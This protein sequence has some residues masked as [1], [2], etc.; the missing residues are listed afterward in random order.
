[1]RMELLRLARGNTTSSKRIIDL[2]TKFV[3]GIAPE[4]T[5]FFLSMTQISELFF[6][7][8][9]QKAAIKSPP[10]PEL[11][12]LHAFSRNLSKQIGGKTIDKFSA[13]YKKRLKT[14]EK[15]LKLGVEGAKVTSVYRD[16][17]ELHFA[18]DNGNVLAL[19]LMLKGEL[20]LFEG[21][22]NKKYPIIELIFS[23][24]TG[25]AMTDWQGQANAT[26]NPEPRS[27]P[28]ALSETIDHKFLKE[29]LARSRATVK[30]LLM[31]QQ[32]IRGIGNAYADEILWNARISPF[33]ISNKIPDPAIKDL[34]KSMRLVLTKAEKTILKNHPDI[35][36]GENR[37]LLSIHNAKKENSPTGAKIRSETMGGR[38][39]F[40]TD[41]QKLYQ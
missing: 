2:I 4:F 23:D 18:L 33:S 14:G 39:T 22:H 21:T 26:L 3:Q 12:D 17:K 20:H 24:G 30:K 10:M 9:S 6:H 11:P 27:A 29:L 8:V 34:A 28:D 37:D 15:E 16:G 7:F 40:Y 41:E 31:D 19:H 32:L 13:V 38:K 36:S 5:F 25:L 35:I 1:M